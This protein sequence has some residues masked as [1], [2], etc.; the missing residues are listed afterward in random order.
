MKT[1]G[2]M[3]L[4]MGNL[5]DHGLK[6]VA[7]VDVE[8]C[9]DEI[10]RELEEEYVELPKDADGEYIH[11]G[12]RMECDGKAF[13]VIA[14]SE[15]QAFRANM[16]CEILP[17]DISAIRHHKPPTVEDV[18]EKALNEAA[19]LDRKEGYWPSAADI[20]NIVNELSPRLQLREDG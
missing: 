4:H 20:T 1:I 11:I 18:L 6:Q 19:M 13:D 2:E 8:R 5:R 16:Y 10:E 17:V 7:M 15:T 12:D 3:K 14:L 9:L